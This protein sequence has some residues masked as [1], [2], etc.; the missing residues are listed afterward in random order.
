M[1]AVL[2]EDRIYMFVKFQNNKDHL[3]SLQK[4]Q[5]YMN[6]GRYFAELE[7]KS[8]TKG[9]G[10]KY[11]LS[12][13]MNKVSLSFHHSE[14]SELL[15]EAE[16]DVL[17]ISMNAYMTKPLFCI[18]QIDSQS[19]KIVKEY[20]ESVDCQ[21]DFGENDIEQ[22]VKDFG[23]YAL[24]ISPGPFKER[25]NKALIDQGLLAHQGKISYVDYK[26]N[27]VERLESYHEFDPNHFF[28]KDLSFSHQREYRIVLASVDSEEPF[29]LDIDDLTDISILIE[30]RDL[31]SGNFSLKI[32]KD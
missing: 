11:E 18:T 29:V 24:I 25:L 9:I 22:L 14:T 2:A 8:G 12:Q 1:V 4:G 7:K 27:S 6:N 10:D 23:E 13:V 15:F 5:L 3:L 17:S 30:T 28:I 32:A 26:V 21:F 20:E 16:A 19:L 31:F